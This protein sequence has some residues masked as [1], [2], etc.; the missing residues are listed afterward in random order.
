ML[1]KEKGEGINKMHIADCGHCLPVEL[2][3][4]LIFLYPGATDMQMRGDGACFGWTAYRPQNVTLVDEGG[5]ALISV[6][7]PMAVEGV[8]DSV[9]PAALRV[10]NIKGFSQKITMKMNWISRED[11]RD[12]HLRQDISDSRFNI[13][14]EVQINTFMGMTS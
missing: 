11:S 3:H 8:Q 4:P 1:L 13:R 12:Q 5:A 9:F 10:S 14:H 7:L 2:F 6:E